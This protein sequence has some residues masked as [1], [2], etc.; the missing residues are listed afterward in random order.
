MFHAVWH[1]QGFL[2][3]SE[4][5]SCLTFS[6]CA[7]TILL[8]T[9]LSFVSAHCRSDEGR[10]NSP[11]LCLLLHTQT[12]VEIWATLMTKATVCGNGGQEE[13]SPMENLQLTLMI[14]ALHNRGL[15]S[16]V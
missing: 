6:S 7:V 16:F 10:L 13:F 15:A 14:T 4:E 12:P 5:K 8:L 1:M 11:T 2:C 3:V 9:L